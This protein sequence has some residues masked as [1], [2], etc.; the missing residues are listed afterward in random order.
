[1]T[2]SLRRPIQSKIG[3]PVSEATRPTTR[4]MTDI[5]ETVPAESTT[6]WPM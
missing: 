6:D 4:V 3:P 2:G 5:R 1:M